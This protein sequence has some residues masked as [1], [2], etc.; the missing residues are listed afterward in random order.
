MPNHQSQNQI[1][2]ATCRQMRGYRTGTNA[3]ISR[4]YGCPSVP[5]IVHASATA[6]RAS[7]ASLD[8]LGKKA[9]T[10]AVPSAVQRTPTLCPASTASSSRWPSP[11]AHCSVTSRVRSIT[12]RRSSLLFLSPS[13]AD[14]NYNTRARRAVQASGSCTDSSLGGTPEKATER[15]QV[16]EARSRVDTRQ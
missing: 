3:F 9:S 13:A 6:V 12:M 8:C 7:L 10:G 11:D 4:E 15:V 5:D 16:D 1:T 2:N 14:S